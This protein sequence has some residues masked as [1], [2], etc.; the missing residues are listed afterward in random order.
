[1]SINGLDAILT[2]D[3]DDHERCETHDLWKPCFIC[4][5]EAIEAA[6]E[7]QREERA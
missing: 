4:Q 7:S 1:M 5:H 6:H 3:P 2:S